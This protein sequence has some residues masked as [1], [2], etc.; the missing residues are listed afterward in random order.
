MH[1]QLQAAAVV[2]ALCCVRCVV[3]CAACMRAARA[4]A[5]C[6]FR[7]VRGSSP[8][9]LGRVCLGQHVVMLLRIRDWARMGCWACGGVHCSVACIAVSR[10]RRGGAADQVHAVWW[11][12]RACLWLWL[13][14]C[15]RQAGRRPAAAQPGACAAAKKRACVGR[16]SP[17]P[18]AAFLLMRQPAAGTPPLRVSSA[19]CCVIHG[20]CVACMC[21]CVSCVASVGI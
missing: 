13:W 5:S 12:C 1:A 17:A 7:V 21:V 4:C 9:L 2:F 14:T 10:G 15:V 3:Q 18:A 6:A 11:A 19:C 16:K 8:A 20:R